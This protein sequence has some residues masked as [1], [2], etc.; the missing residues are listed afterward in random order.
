VEPIPESKHLDEVGRLQNHFHAMQQSLAQHMQ[1]LQQLSDTLK[2]RGEVLQDA[3]EQAQGADRIKTNF[4]YNM[5]DQMKAPVSSILQ[6]VRSISQHGS[7]LT[8]ED[9]NKIVD[10]IMLRGEK[11]T[12]LLNQLI[13]D[14]EKLEVRSEKKE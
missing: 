5:S 7:E 9:T 13:A 2:E 12:A 6:S 4:L 10:D 8:D 11:V 14:S 1:E 3:Y